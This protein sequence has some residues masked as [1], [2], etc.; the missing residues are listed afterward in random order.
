MT[1]GNSSLSDLF[2]LFRFMQLKPWY[3]WSE[4]RQHIM[5]FEKKRPDLAGKRAQAILRACMLR[6]KK[7]SKLYVCNLS[8][9]K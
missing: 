3:D 9:L 4:F 6:R 5:T 7:D 2:P 1:L 8:S